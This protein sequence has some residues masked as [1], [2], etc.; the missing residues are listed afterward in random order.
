MRVPNILPIFAITALLVAIPWT[1]SRAHEGEDHDES[2]PIPAVVSVTPRTEAASEKL[3]LVAIADSGML[4]IYVARLRTNDPVTNAAITVETPVGSVFASPEHDGTY[5][6]SA[7]WAVTRGH[8]DLIF[9]VESDA[10]AEVLTATLEIPTAAPLA[11]SGSTGTND[12]LLS[13]LRQRIEGR[14]P[15]LILSSIA[16]FVLGLVVMGLLA[17][18]KLVPT[19]ALL[20]I[21]AAVLTTAALAHEGE[22][23]SAAAVHAERPGPRQATARWLPVCAETYPKAACDPNGC[24]DERPPSTYHRVAG[25]N[26]PRSECKRVCTGLR[27]RTSLCPNGRISSTRYTS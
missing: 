20:A 12:G 27:R 26:H 22:D 10:T 7:P 6:L 4:T 15:P 9:T 18:R 14:D 1:N 19:V 17:R 16:G 13:Q 5:K 3:E 23:H 24:S 25:A 11:Q 2:R 21:L 8:H